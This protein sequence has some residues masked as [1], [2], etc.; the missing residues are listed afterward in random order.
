MCPDKVQIVIHKYL[1]HILFVIVSTYLPC[2]AQNVQY[3][4]FPRFN[5]R[6]FIVVK[7]YTSCSTNLLINHNAECKGLHLCIYTCHVFI[8]T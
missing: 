5:V 4:Q 8:N 7:I 2:R 6:H 1:L 3:H